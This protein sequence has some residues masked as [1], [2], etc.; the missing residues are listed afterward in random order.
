[1]KNIVKLLCRWKFLRIS[2]GAIAGFIVLELG[3]YVLARVIF[4]LSAVR[5]MENLAEFQSIGRFDGKLK[6]ITY[7]IC[8]G[9]GGD[10]NKFK[11]DQKMIID[12]LHA[13]SAMLSDEK[14]DIAVLE[15]VDFDSLLTGR[16]NQAKYIAEKAGYPYWVEQKN[17]DAQTLFAFSERNGN[18]VLSRYPISKAEL[19]IFPGH[20]K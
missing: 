20:K 8:H 15:E 11:R 5:V 12:R 17:V 18:A 9:W 14:P 13:V 2:A 7:N 16:M 6:I 3:Y 4:P 19:V 10:A 1:M